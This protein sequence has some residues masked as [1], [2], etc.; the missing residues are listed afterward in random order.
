MFRKRCSLIPPA[1]FR[2]PLRDVIEIRD[3]FR[4]TPENMGITLGD[5]A[6]PNGRGTIVSPHLDGRIRKGK[7][8]VYCATFQMVWETY[9]TI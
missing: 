7:N 1:V 8:V 2:E 6:V 4:K 9:L 5:R 3:H